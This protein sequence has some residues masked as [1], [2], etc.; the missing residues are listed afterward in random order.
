MT[1]DLVCQVGLHAAR[2]IGPIPMMRAAAEPT[3][4]WGVKTFARVNAIMVDGAGMWGGCRLTVRGKVVFVCVD[5]PEL[6]THQVGFT[7]LTRRNRAC[8]E[9]AV[10]IHALVDGNQT[11]REAH[12]LTERIE[13]VIEQIRP[14]ADVTVHPEPRA[15]GG[16]A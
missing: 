6:D 2:V 10:D 8:V 1:L 5:G 13:H 14:E 3:R 12:D 15:P 16:A 11:L 4:E 9:Q 7:E